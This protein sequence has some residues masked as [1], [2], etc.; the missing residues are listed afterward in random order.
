ME[1]V[2]INSVIETV[3]SQLPIGFEIIK[4]ENGK[5]EITLQDQDYFVGWDLILPI[6]KNEILDTLN[7]YDFEGKDDV[8]IEIKNPSISNMDIG[9]ESVSIRFD[10][11]DIDEESHD[12]LRDEDGVVTKYVFSLSKN[13][14][15]MCH[16][17][18][19]RSVSL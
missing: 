4:R 7:L 19:L 13:Q 6:I 8:Y 10:K 17:G 12:S 1:N 5:V 16:K 3:E 14:L 9:L 15:L 11:K 2:T 18:M